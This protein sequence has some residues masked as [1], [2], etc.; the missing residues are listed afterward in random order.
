MTN[1]MLPT[2]RAVLVEAVMPDTGRPEQEV[3]VPLLGVPSTGV[4]S[5]GLVNVL[6]VN[7]SVVARPT[8]VSVEV[9][10]VRVPVLTIELIV[11]VV[12]VLFV[13]VRVLEAVA[14]VTPSMVTIPAPERARVVSLS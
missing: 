11:G 10:N 9:G 8:S 13:S 14:T 6:L 5:V 2:P 12:N 3:K 7:V 4:V 1:S